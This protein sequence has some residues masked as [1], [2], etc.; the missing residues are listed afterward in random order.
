MAPLDDPMTVVLWTAVPVELCSPAMLAFRAS[1]EVL[2]VN[3]NAVRGGDGMPVSNHPD[4]PTLQHWQAGGAVVFGYGSSRAIAYA[5]RLL[6]R[7][8][9]TEQ[10]GVAVRRRF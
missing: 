2:R 6:E 9:V 7:V 5:R 8:Y 1:A 4:N 10:G 3:D